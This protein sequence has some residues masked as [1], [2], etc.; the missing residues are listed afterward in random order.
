[1]DSYQ[2]DIALLNALHKKDPKAFF[3]F[4]QSGD[5]RLM[6]FPGKQNW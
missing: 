2:N 1:M 5:D 4:S 3:Q 6:L